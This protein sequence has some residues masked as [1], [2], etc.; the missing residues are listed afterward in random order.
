MRS[1]TAL[2]RVADQM[3]IRRFFA[4]AHIVIAPEGVVRMARAMS[5]RG[6][7]RLPDIRG[8][9]AAG[10]GVTDDAVLDLVRRSRDGPYPWRGGARRGQGRARGAPGS[11]GRRRVGL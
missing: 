10:K 9:R 4:L 5:N 6:S 8:K 1:A 2:P 3:Q 7:C 11:R